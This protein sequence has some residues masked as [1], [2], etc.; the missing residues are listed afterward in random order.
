MIYFLLCFI[1]AISAFFNNA[2]AIQAIGNI[3]SN[4]VVER[5]TVTHDGLLCAWDA[6]G[7]MRDGWPIDKSDQGELFIMQPHLVD[8]DSDLQKEIISITINDEHEY[9]LYLFKGNSDEVINRKLHINNNANL[10]ETP[11]IADIN[12]DSF[13]EIIYVLSDNSI[14]I[15]NYKFEL[16]QN[17]QDLILANRPFITIGDMD[18][19]GITNL[20]ANAGRHV[21]I[22]SEVGTRSILYSMP[23]GEEIIGSISILN[24]SEMRIIITTTG[25]KVYILDRNGNLILNKSNSFSKI[26]SSPNVVDIDAD[27]EKEIVFTTDNNKYVFMELNGDVLT[28]FELSN[29]NHIWNTPSFGLVANDSYSGIFTSL[30]GYDQTVIYNS[31][32]GMAKLQFGQF[33]HRFDGRANLVFIDFVKINDVY[34]QPFIFS[35]NQDGINDNVVIH[36][37]LS[38]DADIGL[39][40]Y[41]SNGQF[42]SSILLP[43]ASGITGENELTW[44]GEIQDGEFIDS[45]SYILKLKAINAYGVASY[46]KTQVIAFGIKAEIEFPND[47]NEDDDVFPT[48]H[49]KVCIKGTAMDPNIGEQNLSSDFKSYKLYVRSGVWVL[50]PADVIGIGENASWNP[51]QVPLVHQ[52]SSNVY[53]EMIDSLYPE[54]NISTRQV[55]HGV[56]GVLDTH[57]LT[58]GLYTVILK[59]MDSNGNQINKI[60]YDTVVI[61]V[62]N[63]VS[64]EIDPEN[65]I[66]LEPLDPDDPIYIGPQISDLSVSN[67]MISNESYDSQITYQLGDANNGITNESANIEVDIYQFN[68]DTNSIEHVVSSFMFKNIA[69]GSYTIDWDGRSNTGRKLPGGTYKVRATAFAIDGTGVDYR[70]SDIITVFHSYCSSDNLSVDENGFSVTPNPFYPYNFD[71]NTG[72]PE[73]S[74]IHY[75]LS[76][77]ASTS[78]YIFDHDP[79]DDPNDNNGLDPIKILVQDHVL[80][81]NTFQWDGTNDAG[82]I[83]PENKQYFIK[84]IASD[85][86]IGMEEERIAEVISMRV[87]KASMHT[88]NSIISFIKGDDDVIV[89]NHLENPVNTPING[90]PRFFWRGRGTGYL[91]AGFS[92][93]IAAKGTQHWTHQLTMSEDIDIKY[94]DASGTQNQCLR[95]SWKY[96]KAPMLDSEKNKVLEYPADMALKNYTIGFSDDTVDG[97]YAQMM[98]NDGARSQYI[99]HYIRY[100]LESN[101][102]YTNSGQDG[103]IFSW[104]RNPLNGV[105]YIHADHYCVG[106]NDLAFPENEYPDNIMGPGTGNC[107]AT[108]INGE[109][110]GPIYYCGQMAIDLYFEKQG[111]EDWGWN[112]VFKEIQSLRSNTHNSDNAIGIFDGTI[113]KDTASNGIVDSTTITG[114]TIELSNFRFNG[115]DHVL[116]SISGHIRTGPL[117]L[118]QSSGNVYAELSPSVYQSSVHDLFINTLSN[119]YPEANW[120]YIEFNKNDIDF[121]SKKTG[122]HNIYANYQ[123]NHLKEQ[124]IESN[125]YTFS[126]I[127]K[128]N[129]WEQELVYP[130]NTLADAF[131]VIN[132]PRDI[133]ADGIIDTDNAREHA[134]SIR[135]KA[136]G[137]PKKFISIYGDVGENSYNLYYYDNS[138][139]DASWV[140]IAPAHARARQLGVLGFWDVT[141]LNGDKYTL[142]LR[143]YN[144]DDVLEDSMN[145]SI[146]TAI[147]EEGG[148]VYSALGRVSLLF[149]ENT[150]SDETLVSI[151]TIDPSK[152]NYEINSAIPIG[153]IFEI[154]PDDIDI[155]LN[156]PAEL[157]IVYTCDEMKEL[158]G[159]P[160]STACNQI[161]ISHISIYH[162]KA[163]N[164]LESLFTSILWDEPQRVYR[165][166]AV[167]EHFSQYVLGNETAGTFYI[168]SPQANQSIK[169]IISISGR[170]ETETRENFFSEG[171]L[172]NIDMLTVYYLDEDNNKHIVF[173]GDQSEL[174][175]NWDTSSLDGNYRLLF[176]AKKD[177]LESI[178]SIPIAIDN[179]G[180]SSSMQVNGQVVLNNDEIT[181]PSQSIIEIKST[182]ETENSWQSGV[183]RIEYSFNGVDF[184]LYEGPFS[185]ASLEQGR[186]ELY[187]RSLDL[188]GNLEE[189]KIGFIMISDISDSNNIPDADINIELND[190]TFTRDNQTWCSPDTSF[191]VHTEGDYQSILCSTGD[192]SYTAYTEV[193]YLN[194]LDMEGLHIINCYGIDRNGFRGR[195]Y[196]KKVIYDGTSVRLN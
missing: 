161:D 26:I 92:Y 117:H 78:I 118:W 131:L 107:I 174:N 105:I 138:E 9:T 125:L 64:V 187:Y 95:C 59:T 116:P 14:N 171:E 8:I 37:S 51:V 167:L 181:V 6:H 142:L 146:G 130:D 159:I 140:S 126:D 68:T 134:I 144:G 195:N 135:L 75:R 80:V 50:A 145:V 73:T 136:T 43:D 163:D 90:D 31:Q 183:D 191:S 62:E 39:D 172:A 115:T 82:V 106:S 99:P 2:H 44:N 20:V 27:G 119:T 186:H 24:A 72:K 61:S 55:Q 36:Y 149:S 139:D 154:L 21:Y 40:L 100:S 162:V 150:V 1:A 176:H 157:E 103:D 109:N 56:L 3:D 76:K 147:D 79:G 57:S 133:N 58:N 165:F 128:I 94:E 71:I 91:E 17:F 46:A 111:T 47:E 122:R 85:I 180:S 48:V 67:R 60:S 112:W 45:G 152:S 5:I 104:M 129:S 66:L 18:N 77:A 153:P 49:G 89:H 141:H 33:L 184:L 124:P 155:N 102:T 170:L 22:W 88:S 7:N 12:Q 156:H 19:N 190:Y 30:N 97:I 13:L 84:L 83:V 87:N 28:A 101:N 70:E 16:E 41:R 151:N 123:L 108:G 143:V 15:L 160:W 121:N 52:D 137:T 65:D 38:D 96:C 93:K 193:F 74:S 10:L 179:S 196:S 148:R 34:A 120:M 35:P 81:S 185:L 168:D 192:S 177:Q 166:R 32:L 98:I 158:L 173:E 53:T 54:S 63:P 132:D 69:P 175:L 127:V 182:D 164:E 110:G 178:Y 42:I 114:Y 23:E 194:S 113:G 86:D 4:S 11:I 169:G 188:V 189:T 25:N 29:D